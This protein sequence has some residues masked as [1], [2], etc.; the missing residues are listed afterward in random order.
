MRVHLPVLLCALALSSRAEA[1]GALDLVV[2]Q[3]TQSLGHAPASSMV[4]AAPLASDEPAPKGND[5]ALRVAALIAG[6]IGAGARVHAQTTRL[7]PARSIAGRA[8]AL[9]YVQTELAKGDLR[10][11]VDVY[12]S[13]ANAWDRIRNPVPLPI[14]HAFAST[15]IDAEVRS[16][17]LPLLLEQA[18]VHRARQDEP[19]VLAAACGDIDGDGGDEIVLVSRERVVLGRVRGARFVVE[20]SA[21]WSELTPR[22]PVP[23][24]EPLAGAAFGVGTV[25]VGLTER[26][27]FSLARDFAERVRLSGMPAWGGT[28]VV[29]LTA[30]PSAGAFDGAPFDC[31][32]AREA[33]PKM[34]VPAP[35][36]DAFAAATIANAQG[37]SLLVV[38]VR[39]PSGKLKLKIGDTP[40]IAVDG[41]F[42][43]Q[44]AVWDLDQDGVPEIASSG[45]GPEDVVEV[46]SWQPQSASLRLRLHLLAPGGVRA[47]A[48]CP[49]E[50]RGLPVLV[51][52]VGNELWVVRS[53]V[54]EATP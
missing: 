2:L 22:A 30:E 27:A 14:E 38:A 50:E 19:G 24:R 33:K 26:G 34:A 51:A 48:V 11:T 15:K 47:L 16:F 36:F 42:G 3:A 45:S 13:T 53:G 40:P 32:I 9:V 21:P 41:T 25:A 54:Q 1:A 35:R 37:T 39:E 7:E 5:L 52:V 44:L 29:C 28:G 17:L 6:R 49:P 8:G 31:A 20:K 10:A 12:P 46:R 23:T 43:A 4:V 18:S